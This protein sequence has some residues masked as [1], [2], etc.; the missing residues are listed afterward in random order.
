[1]LPLLLALVAAVVEVAVVATEQVAVVEA[2]RAAVRAAAVAPPGADVSG[3][4]RAAAA[5]AAPGLASDRLVV[6]VAID[7]DVG[8]ATAVVRFL[9]RPQI[10][11]LDRFLP[12]MELTATE[13][14]EKESDK[15]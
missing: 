8:E 9:A 3:R 11:L 14:M 7:D 10:P 4:A 15:N 2:G 5:A 12:A 6:T 1:M 13:K